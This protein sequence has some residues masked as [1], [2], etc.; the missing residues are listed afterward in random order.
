MSG[1]LTFNGTSAASFGLKIGSVEPYSGPVQSMKTY[2]V[3]GR[4]GEVLP[5]TDL[6]QIPNQII[7]YDAALYMKNATDSA[8]A[9]RMAQI[10]KWLLSPKGYQVLMDSYDP[11]VYRRAYLVGDIVPTRKGAGQ[12]FSMKLSFSC[13][14]RRF[15]RN[16]T[17]IELEGASVTVA[18]PTTINGYSVA[19]QAKPLIQFSWSGTAKFVIKKHNKST[20]IGSIELANNT[21]NPRDIW[22]DAETLN[23]TYDEAGTQNANS[24][25]ANVT[26]EI[27]LGP[28]AMDL[29]WEYGAV[30]DA[31]ITQRYWTR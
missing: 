24:L 1:T 6:S 27:R 10:R 28:E 20:V 14:P 15:I 22:F 25:I 23:A 11:D 16:V 7:T 29:S 5:R 12:S 19:N 4:I 17:P 3:P 18:T 26:G 21:D 8:V 2:N 30:A 31:I 13:D 9:K